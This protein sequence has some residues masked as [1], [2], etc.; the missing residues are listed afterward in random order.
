MSAKETRD[1]ADERIRFFLDKAKNE[2]DPLAIEAAYF[3]VL[4]QAT[5]AYMKLRALNEPSRHSEELMK[6]LEKRLDGRR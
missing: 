1:Y 2:T 5:T 6:A 3:A 4:Q